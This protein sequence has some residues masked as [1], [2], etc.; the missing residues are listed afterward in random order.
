MK[1]KFGLII[2]VLA[3]AATVSADFFNLKFY[4]VSLP[5]LSMTPCG[6]LNNTHSFLS[7]GKVYDIPQVSALSFQIIAH[8]KSHW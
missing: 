1:Q 4:R 8:V 2:G 5:P 6:L 7:P 3:S